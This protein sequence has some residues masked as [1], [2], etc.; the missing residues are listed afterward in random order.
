VIFRDGTPF[1]SYGGD[2]NAF[3][4]NFANIE[5][6]EILKGP[7]AILYGAVEPGGIVNVNTKQPQATPA[8]SLEQQIGSYGLSRTTFNATGPLST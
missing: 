3:A 1:Y 4:L 7:A 8:Y 2:S 5:N 6:V